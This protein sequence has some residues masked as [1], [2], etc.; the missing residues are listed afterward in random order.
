MAS[1]CVASALVGLLCCCTGIIDCA[2]CAAGKG[3][4]A[5]GGLSARDHAAPE[6]DIEFSNTPDGYFEM[7]KQLG[8]AFSTMYGSSK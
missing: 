3:G 5:S 2:A 4:L 7:G 1:C 8:V 6:P